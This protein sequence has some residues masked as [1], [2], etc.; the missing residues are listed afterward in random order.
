VGGFL[1]EDVYER[2]RQKINKW[3]IKAPKSKSMLKLLSVVYSPEEAELVSSAFDTP[4]IDAK[5]VEQVAKETGKDVG[6]VK[7]VFERLA[8]KGGLFEFT[9]RKDDNTYYSMVPYAV[10]LFEFHLNDGVITDEKREFAKLHEDIYPH[11]GYELGSSN[12]PYMRVIPVEEKLDARTEILPFEKVSKYIEEA[13]TVA[14]NPCVCRLVE[15]NCDKPLEVCL[16]FDSGADYMVKHRNGRQVTKEEAME[17]LRKAEDAGLVHTINNQQEKPIL[18]CNCCADCC[19]VLRGLSQLHNPRAFT[20]S[21]FMPKIDR[22]ICRVCET[23]VKWCPFQALYRHYPHTEDL[24]DDMIM[25]LEERCIGCGV[26]A[27][28]CPHDAITLVRVRE[29]IPEKS[30]RDALMRYV[31]EKIH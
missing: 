29:E 14:V 21:N 31:A 15:N 23:C 17:I 3:P 25:V 27:H 4:F 26:C 8:D 20:K 6:Y 12:Y 22:E 13:R 7:T 9:N 30:G 16:S 24:S 2:L 18:I 5:T 19:F 28:K 10:G 11:W 1:S